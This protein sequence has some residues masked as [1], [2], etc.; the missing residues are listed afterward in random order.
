M[1]V[2]SAKEAAA[3]IQNGNTLLIGGSSGIAVAESVLAAL[4][5][6]FLETGMPQ[7]LFAVST[8]GLGDKDKRGMNHVAHEGMLSRTLC[9]HYGLQPSVARLARE[10][11]IEAYN[12]PQGVMA[13]LYGAIAAHKPGVLTDVGLNTYMDPRS[14][15]GRMNECTTRN[16]VEVLTIDGREWLLYKSFPIHV[17][18]LRGTT[19][20][21]DGNITCEHEACALESLSAAQAAHNSGGIVIVEVKR[22]AK[23]GTL[24]PRQVTIPGIV[25]DYV[26][27]D[28]EPTMTWKTKFDPSFIGEVKK[29][30]SQIVPLALNERKVIARRAAMELTAGAVVNLGSGIS[31][32]IPNVAVEEHIIDQVTITIESGVIGGMAGLELD[33][34]TATNPAAMIPQPDMFNFYDGGGLDIAF[35]SFVELDQRGNINV[36]KLSG[37]I[38]GPGG[39]MNISANAKRMCFLGT[40]TAGGLRTSIGGGRMEILQEG[41]YRKFV[42][43]VSHLTWNADHARSVEQKVLYITERAVFELTAEGVML[44]EIAPGLD[45]E[46]DILALIPFRPQIAPELKKMDKRIF[47]DQPMGLSGVEPAVV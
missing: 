26:V 34:G 27:V 24:D 35:L 36:T 47:C 10:N 30:V 21:E 15:G 7:N 18:L 45:L 2:V 38:E 12:F 25:V 6:R 39:F 31:A 23:R 8:G 11:K 19:A 9:G 44:T 22:L 33:F 3:L 17:S 5:K 14:E 1:K 46:R 29:P 42:E 37:Q 28:P 20:D 4:E 43:T 40:F 16:M 13:H 32:G 41:K